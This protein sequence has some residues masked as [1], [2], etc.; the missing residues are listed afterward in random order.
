LEIEKSIWEKRV[1][2]DASAKGLGSCNRVKREVCTKKGKGI[3]I[4]KK[5]ERE[6]TGICGGPRKGYI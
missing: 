6:G 4:V 1:G 2:E 5:R 3:F